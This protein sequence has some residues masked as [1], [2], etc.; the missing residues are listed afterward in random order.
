MLELQSMESCGS[1]AFKEAFRTAKLRNSMTFFS[2]A[3]KLVLGLPLLA[4]PLQGGSS[5]AL[6]QSGIRIGH[7]AKVYAVAA[8]GAQ[9]DTKLM[10]VSG[11][12]PP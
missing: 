8:A 6:G 2:R 5:A 11:E 12:L 1:W 10:A 4:P 7:T 9:F 3:P